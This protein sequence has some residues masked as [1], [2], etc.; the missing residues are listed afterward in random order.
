MEDKAILDLLWNRIES[1]IEAMA[2]KYGSRLRATALNIIGSV[3]DAEEAVSDT[4]FA[5]WNA[6]PPN[7]PDPLSG[8]VYKT[9]RNLALKKLRAN[10]ALK[11]SGN[12]GLSLDELAGCIPG[13]ALEETV[14]ARVLGLAIDAFLGTISRESRVIFLRRYW[15]GDGVKDI[16]RALGMTESAVSV[17]L[18]RTREQLR[19]HLNKEGFLD[20]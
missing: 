7:R 18:H 6:I 1:A 9:G 11:R 16:A 4:Y 3:R 8:F 2:A 10:T 15:F 19:R 12:Y 17:R 13:P 20:E 5:V 14:E